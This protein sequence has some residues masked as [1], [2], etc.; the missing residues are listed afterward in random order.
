MPRTTGDLLHGTVD[1]LILKTLCWGAMHGYAISEWLHA[2]TDGALQL[3]D[4]ALY[5]AL[6]RLSR[7]GAVRAE[8]GVSDN[9][10]RARFYT[11]TARGRA[12]LTEESAA[13][14]GFARS[15]LAVLDA[16]VRE[17]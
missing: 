2:R 6:H 14:R 12:H 13:F 11:I 7:Q 5:Q 15:V 16:R 9:N 3:Q 17:A 8:W 10:R 1:I 4:A